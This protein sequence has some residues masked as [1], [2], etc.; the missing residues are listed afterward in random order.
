MN[1]S[2]LPLHVL[3]GIYG[4]T[5]PPSGISVEGWLRWVGPEVVEQSGR[6]C[7]LGDPGFQRR[8]GAPD[9]CLIELREETARAGGRAL[10]R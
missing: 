3:E 5:N 10:R 2:R 7:E 6:V 9:S 1:R 8:G 4:L